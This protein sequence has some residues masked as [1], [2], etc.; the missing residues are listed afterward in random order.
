MWLNVTSDGGTPGGDG[1]VV[2]GWRCGGRRGIGP[3]GETGGGKESNGE[4]V[5]SFAKVSE[6]FSRRGRLAGRGV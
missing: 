1:R 6:K 3:T 5:T 4:T 2:G